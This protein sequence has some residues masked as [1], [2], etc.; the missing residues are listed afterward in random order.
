MADLPDSA[1]NTWSK[2]ADR[3][4]QLFGR[5][6]A[7]RDQIVDILRE[8]QQ[9]DLLDQDS[10]DTIERVFQVSDLRVRDVMI[11]RSQM[12]VVERSAAP[13]EFLP[14]VI[15]TAHSRFPVIDGDRDK[16]I[17]ILLAKDL[18]RY[19]HDRDESRFN[20]RD[21]LREAVF[22]PESKRLNVL[23]SEFRASRNHMAIVVDEY[24]GVAGLVTI[25]DVLEQIV[26]EIEDEHDIDDEAAM[27]MQRGDNDY[28]VKALFELE[29]FNERFGTAFDTEEFDTIG[30]LII[31]RFGHMPRRGERVTI[32]EMEF[33]VL[34]A[35]S[36]RVHLLRVAR[37]RGQPPVP[38]A[39]NS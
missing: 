2:W 31:N 18:L 33:E 24:G 11:P 15:E 10:L 6:P 25:E 19:F 32:E 13:E 29:D 14:V 27:V 12:A 38:S 36:R 8:A 16:V 4:G 1:Q 37:A 17:G 5:E 21:M 39:D 9:R 23:L 20:L 34:H 26:G 30:G 3:I 22:I 7:T 35:D 28:V